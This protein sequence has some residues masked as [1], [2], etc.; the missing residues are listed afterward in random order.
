MTMQ[1]IKIENYKFNVCP[2]CGDKLEKISIVTYD[3]EGNTKNSYTGYKPHKCKQYQK[4]CLNCRYFANHDWCTCLDK[5]KFI[6]EGLKSLHNI[7]I[8][9]WEPLDMKIEDPKKI[10]SFYKPKLIDNCDF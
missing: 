6:Q 8:V 7:S 5:L 4:M 2:K 1:T 3:K 10:C 9:S